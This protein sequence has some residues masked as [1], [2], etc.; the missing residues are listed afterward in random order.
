MA[1]QYGFHTQWK[2]KT[3]ITKIAK[4]EELPSPIQTM[5]DKFA[6]EHFAAGTYAGFPIAESFSSCIPARTPI[7]VFSSNVR[8]HAV[9]CKGPPY[10]STGKDFYRIVDKWAE[11]A[12]PTHNQYPFLLAEMYVCETSWHH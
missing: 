5:D 4:K 3:D 7:Q 9:I 11:F 1:S 8:T 6:Q 2:T 12:V 10:M